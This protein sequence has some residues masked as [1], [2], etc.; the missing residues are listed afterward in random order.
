[1]GSE[2][3]YEDLASQEV[4]KYTYRYVREETANERD[5]YVVERI[6][7][8]Q[9]SGYT[10]HLVWYDKEEYRPEKIEL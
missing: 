6:P 3:A 8:D 7:V 2:F 5:C 10:R 4:D 9:N 1:M